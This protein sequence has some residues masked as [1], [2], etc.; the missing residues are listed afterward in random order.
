MKK[1]LLSAAAAALLTT[2]L[3]ASD[4]SYVGAGVGTGYAGFGINAYYGD[5]LDN[6]TKNLG[7]EADL[8]YMFGQTIGTYS[9][10]GM[11]LSGMATYTYPVADK[12]ELMAGLGLGYYKIGYTSSSLDFSVGGIGIAYK[13]QAKY[14]LK[15]K[16]KLT[17]GYQNYYYGVGAEIPFSF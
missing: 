6:V 12:V 8:S 5:N 9:Y 14:A 11:T 2:S 3:S 10:Y 4:K 13:F 7:W 17:V 15:E 1:L 16:L